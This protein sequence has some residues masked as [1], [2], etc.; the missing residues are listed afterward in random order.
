MSAAEATNLCDETEK[1]VAERER[2][3]QLRRLA[4]HPPS[5][6]R[7]LYR[8]YSSVAGRGGDEV[9]QLDD[10]GLGLGKPN[11]GDDRH[12]LLSEALERLGRLPA[13]EVASQRSG[14]AC[15]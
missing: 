15:L 7:A 3:A 9:V 2:Q 8:L 14:P 10:V 11:L 5:P 4:R 6:L 12:Q 1:S 13:A